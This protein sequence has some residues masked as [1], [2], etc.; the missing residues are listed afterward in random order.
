LLEV[1]N[2]VSWRDQVVGTVASQLPSL[3]KSQRYCD[4]SPSGS[5]EFAALKL[6]GGPSSPL[7]GLP[8][9]AVGGK[10]EG[11]VWHLTSWKRFANHELYLTKVDAY[12][13]VFESLY[14]C[15]CYKYHQ[16]S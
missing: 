4:V 1:A 12:S 11:P 9:S 15:Y 14:I 13:F 10:L 8:A 3:S 6:I 5:E 16:S 2:K 7:Y